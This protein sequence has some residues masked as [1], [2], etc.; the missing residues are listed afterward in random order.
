MGTLYFICP[1]TGNQVSTG[2]EIDAV[3]FEKLR[4]E[5][6]RC[7]HCQAPHPISGV[8]AWIGDAVVET[9]RLMAGF[10]ASR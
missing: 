4:G 10:A 5:N 6:V 8:Q 2:I 3:T 1:V 9:L 7:P